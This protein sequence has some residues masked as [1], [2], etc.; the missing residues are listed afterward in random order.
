MHRDPPGSWNGERNVGMLQLL[1]APGFGWDVPGEIQ[2]H[3]GF[4]SR[5]GQSQLGNSCIVAGAEVEKKIWWFL[6]CTISKM[7]DKAGKVPAAKPPQLRSSWKAG[8]GADS[9]TA[10]LKG[11]SA[12]LMDEGASVPVIF[13]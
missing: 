7:P 6:G 3:R 13:C 1:P 12:Q 4:G 9:S 8:E 11:S 2:E 5:A 10:T